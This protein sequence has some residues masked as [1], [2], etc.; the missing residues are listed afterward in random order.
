[1]AGVYSP[2]MRKERAFTLIE[3]LVVIGII[4]ILSALLLPALS[5]GKKK[6]QGVSCLNNGHQL[7]TALHLYTADNRD[8]F[9]P[10]PDDANTV[11]GHNWCSGKAGQGGAA[12]FNPDVLR[13]PNLSLLIN[14]VGNNVQVFRCPSDQRMGLYNGTNAAMLGQTVP[15][16]R[17]FSM[18][19][20]CGTICDGYDAHWG[21]HSG[22]PHLA[23]NGSWLDNNYKNTRDG[24]WNT[25]GKFSNIAAPGPA[26]LWVFI[27]EDATDLNDAAFAFGMQ[28]PIWYDVPGTYHNYGCGFAFADGHSETHQWKY[29]K[30]KV[31]WGTSV[32]DDSDYQD[33]LW[34]R[35][36]T[37]AHSDGVMPDA[38][39]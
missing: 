18:N 20:A 4:S 23:V 21:Q 39:R 17:T 16:A 5:R 25:Y 13:D 1:M 29:R 7:M 31:G 38:H 33:W 35:D 26:A 37:S 36:H 19:Q 2:A 12:E 27:D 14:Y 6:A 11:P 28:R 8:L 34:M 3:L 24:P 30:T 22:S 9:P 32:A 10:N 15:S